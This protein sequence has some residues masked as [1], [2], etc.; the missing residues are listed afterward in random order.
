V[1]FV[2]AAQ[3]DWLG[4]FSYSDEEGSPAFAL[5]DKVPPREIERRRRKLM[6]AQRSISRRRRKQMI[7]RE[8]EVM[9]EGPSEETELLWDART[10]AHAPEIDGKVFINDFGDHEDVKPGEFYRAEVTEAHDYD[11]VARL[12]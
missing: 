10:Q 7:G 1:E 6:Q 9:L 11:L 3:F 4:V 8:V 12:L 2:K 5:K